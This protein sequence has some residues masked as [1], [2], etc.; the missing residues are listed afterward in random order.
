MFKIGRFIEGICLNG[1]EYI[2]DED[3]RDNL[4]F[5]TRELAIEY[6]RDKGFIFKDE[7][8]LTDRLGVW[9]L[10]KAIWGKYGK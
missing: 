3:N 2:M 1:Y 5:D 10:N 6:L 4:I 9:I 7:D 8:D